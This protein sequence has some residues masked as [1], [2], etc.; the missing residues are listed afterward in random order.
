[1]EAL[2]GLS[3][4]CN[5]MQVLSFAHGTF[6]LCE[7]LYDEGKANPSLDANAETMSVLASKV[8]DGCI[9]GLT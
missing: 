3:L 9:V 6:L 4:A 8:I 7:R 2:A 1:M 5:V